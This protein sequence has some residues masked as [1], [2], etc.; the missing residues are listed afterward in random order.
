MGEP[1]KVVLSDKSIS[2]D[3]EGTSILE[4]NNTYT[5]QLIFAISS[6]IGTNK[7]D[8][9]DL[10]RSTLKSD[11]GYKEV[12]VIKL[13]EVITQFNTADVPQYLDKTPGFKKLKS[14]IDGGNNIRKNRGCEFLSEIAIAKI[15]LDSRLATGKDE[16]KPK[17]Y[18]PRRDCYIIDSIK[19]SDE[20]K[21]LRSIYGELFYL[22]SIYAPEE[23]RKDYLINQNNIS[24]AEADELILK[25]EFEKEKYGQNVR[26]TFIE[27]DF[28]VNIYEKEKADLKKDV[29]RYINLI[30]QTE[31][32]TPNQHE[33]AM[34][35]AK[36]ASS[37]SACLSRQ[38]GASI[39]NNKDELISTG[40]NDVPKFG[41]N[42][43][44][45]PNSVKS[46]HRCFNLETG[47]GYC[48]NDKEKDELVHNEE[49]VTSLNNLINK[50]LQ[51]SHKVS[52]KSEDF[53][54][55]KQ[56][57]K[58]AL[59]RNTRLKDLIE[60]SRSVHAEM[61]A[62][63]NGSQL[64]GSEIIGGKL[65]CTTY[66]CHNCIRH[67]IASGI[68]EVYYIEPY[69]KSKAIALH[70]DS[71]TESYNKES[72]KVKVLMY[73]GV[74]PRKFLSFFSSINPRKDSMGKVKAFDKKKARPINARTIQAIYSNE[75]ITIKYLS[76]KGVTSKEIGTFFG[77]G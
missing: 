75:E 44:S 62:I 3:L 48:S 6:P 34:Y 30:F 17:D 37:N 66:P 9:I 18:Q 77:G 4:V 39:T 74:A 1:L 28:F 45:N 5:S 20:L 68:Q 16:P 23:V 70:N 57:I 21:L 51:T 15:H 29:E 33:T 10:I 63:I 60:F 25:D 13:S 54:D 58:V 38:V 14:K 56:S 46:D 11:F 7:K 59:R 65:Y 50:T 31:V 40:W 19:N 22:F 73:N 12:S 64:S 41:G 53:S 69:K 36:S 52:F 61:H 24:P 76:N 26:Q 2:N 8:V 71:V 32:I 55:F 42:L 43:Y 49:I 67:I 27:G 47:Y 35:E 72:N